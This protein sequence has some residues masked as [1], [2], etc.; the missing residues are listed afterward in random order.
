MHAYRGPT[1]LSNATRRAPV[2]YF[3]FAFYE[4]ALLF[5]TFFFYVSLG[6]RHGRI[7]MRVPDEIYRRVVVSRRKRRAK[8]MGRAKRGKKNINRRSTTSL[9]TKCKPTSL[10]CGR[11]EQ[12]AATGKGT[13]AVKTG[14]FRYR[15][16][17]A[18]VQQT[19][20]PLFGL[21]VPIYHRIAGIR[22]IRRERRTRGVRVN[23]R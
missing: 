2:D 9:N 6:R 10:A 1:G 12:S 17:G 8:G 22:T 20:K 15:S 16:G 13:F 19:R 18:N 5:F 4:R 14:A 21:R 7:V 23:D 3:S 11:N